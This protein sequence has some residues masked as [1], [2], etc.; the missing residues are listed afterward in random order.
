MNGRERSRPAASA[1]ATSGEHDQDDLPA[2][3]PTQIGSRTEAPEVEE[4][5][6]HGKNQPRRHKAGGIG[7]AQ[8]DEAGRSAGPIASRRVPTG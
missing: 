2:R 7:V 1:P 3:Q 4:G 6:P 8:A 5:D